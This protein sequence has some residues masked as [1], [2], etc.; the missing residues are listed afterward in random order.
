LDIS[1]TKVPVTIGK[2]SNPRLKAFAVALVVITVSAILYQSLA[3]FRQSSLPSVK[4]PVP[5]QK[6]PENIGP[7][8]GKDVRIPELIEQ[9][10][11]NDDY[12][13]RTYTNAETS[14]WVNCYIAYSGRPRTMVGHKPE[15]CYTGSG[16]MLDESRPVEVATSSGRAIPCNLHRFHMPSMT[17]PVVYVLNFY[18]VSGELSDSERSFSGIRWRWPNLDAD[19]RNYVVQVQMSGVSEASVVDAMRDMADAI[20]EFLPERV[21]E[22]E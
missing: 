6:F 5:L 10:A 18:V 15:T 16:W 17:R 19:S 14:E 4:L 3:R 22:A 8:R 11:A 13:T 2:Y 20:V 9:V 12:L 1:G 21:P 7:W